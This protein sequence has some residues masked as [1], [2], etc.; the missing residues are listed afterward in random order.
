MW[1]TGNDAVNRYDGKMVKVYNLDKY[2]LQCPNLQQGYGFAEDSESNIYIGSTRGLYIYHRNQDK[3]TLQ[4]IFINAPESVAMP[5]AFRDGKIWCFNLKYQ[6]ATYDIRTKQV[7]YLTQLSLD[8]L[9]SV[10]V[11]DLSE[12]IFYYH[13]PFID[14]QGTVWIIGNNNIAG[15]NNKTKTAIYPIGEYVKK[16]KPA[17]ISSCYNDNKIIC[18]TKNGIVEYDIENNT[19]AEV[20]VLNNKKP[21][22]I[23]S[24]NANK[25]FI[26]FNGEQGI[27]F[28]T[29]DYKTV[30]WL[31]PKKS[32]KYTRCYNFSFDKS[33]RLWICDDVQGLIIFDFHP[34]MLNKEPGEGADSF[35]L[36]SGIITFGELPNGNIITHNKVEQ[37][38]I[39]KQLAYLP[40]KFPDDVNTRMATDKFRK[41][42]WFFEERYYSRSRS[43]KILFYKQYQKLELV[44]E[45]PNFEILGQQKDM[46]VFP[47][48]KI[49]CSFEKGLFWLH[50]ETKSVEKVKIIQQ[51]NP[52]KI[53]ILSNSR[54]AVSYLGSDMLLAKV[55]PDNSL[56]VLQKILP[57]VQSFYMQEDTIRNLYWVGTN[58]GIYLF[59]KALKIIKIFDA[60]NGLAGTYIYGLLLDDEGNAYCSHQRGLSRINANT[61]QVVNFDKKDGIQDW[62]FNNRAF[63][64]ATNG[65]LFFGGVSGFNYFKPPLQPYSFYKPEVYVD[66]ILVNNKAYLPDS[67]AN[68]IFKMQ[69]G[70][71]ENNISVKAIVKDLANADVR[72]LIYR[73]V[74][75]DS[76]W[77][78]LPNSSSILFNSLAPDDYTLQLG[79]YDKYT[80]KEIV[81]KTILISIAAPFYSKAWFL[82]FIALIITGLLFWLINRRKLARQKMLFQQQVALEKQRSKITADLHDDIGAS[83]SSLQINSAVASQ[84]M[85]KDEKEQARLVL[86]KIETQTHDL[87]DKIGDIIWSMKPGKE[88]FMTMS[89]RIKNFANEILSAT[90]IGYEIKIDTIID[91]V[92]KD[93]SARKNIVL[94]TKEAINN[95]VKYSNASRLTIN[96]Q[97]Q[98]NILHLRITDNGTGFNSHEISGNGINNMRK[99]VE[100]LNGVFEINSTPQ[101]GT[102]ILAQIPLV[103]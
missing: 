24:I 101:E 92:V 43:A 49:L 86:D 59:D 33:N 42:I 90:N 44:F 40:I 53:N 69:L 3:F 78:Y 38:K 96:L 47:D 88:E 50:P 39:T 81:Q 25:D 55:L 79:T 84:L 67:N 12:N 34:G 76:T 72:Q 29:K 31:E 57:G 28:T 36:G 52:F 46:Q 102:V 82:F 8:P 65:T 11:Y 27:T 91:T 14:R 51:S 4:K 61:F 21:G 56:Q 98:Q 26:V 75:T 2:F 54:V 94:I 9:I 10:H 17:F 83:L 73:I 19:I 18:G 20:N 87:A 64:K 77:K 97:L 71:T 48:G 7:N 1:L 23:R 63:Y 41:G 6:L 93:I 99:R 22:S 30:K 66:E 62:D 85:H 15:Y 95:A 32:D 60:N 5:F 70:Y 100:E 35:R 89:S 68:N 45:Q 13:F 58:K 37:N 80:N 16:N 74:E 103:P